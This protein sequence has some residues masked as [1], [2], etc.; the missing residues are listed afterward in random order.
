VTTS[1][2]AV[3][4]AEEIDGLRC[5]GAALL[6]HRRYPVGALWVTAPQ[7]RLSEQQLSTIGGLVKAHALRI[8]QRFGYRLPETKTNY[9][10][11]RREAVA[12]TPLD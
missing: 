12:K 3:D 8:S 2:F 4:R 11:L 6:D 10:F 9:E 7:G 5:V 1:G